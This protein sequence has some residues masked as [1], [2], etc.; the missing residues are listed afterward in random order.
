MSFTWMSKNVLDEN[1]HKQYN[2]V[3]E[4]GAVIGMCRDI[5][6]R[7]YS[8]GKYGT[9]DLMKALAGKYGK[10][11]SFNDA[12]LFND[13][14]KFTY[15]EIGEFL[16]KHVSGTQPLPI[17]EVFDKIGIDFVDEYVHYEFTIGNPDLDF[18]ETTS[19][20]KV[21]GTWDLDAF[22]KALGFKMGDEFNKLNGKELK[23][24]SAKEIFND[25]FDNVKE[26][27]LVKIEVYRPKRK[28]GKYK[29]KT[30][31][32]KARK[33]KIVER[34]QLNLRENITEKEK[35][36]LRSWLGLE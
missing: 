27:D 10:D 31:S 35:F 22:G 23:L 24:D 4:K 34:N 32:A 25:Y 26:G 36:I 2:N 7:N 17:K 28:A 14:E 29:V 3:Y 33:I 16:R 19:R 20:L 5:L 12:D 18:N 30:L 6:L 1:I 9:Q 21:V 15:P 8:N 11:R 13:I